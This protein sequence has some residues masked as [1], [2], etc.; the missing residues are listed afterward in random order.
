[1]FYAL[2]LLLVFTPHQ[3][4]CPDRLSSFTPLRTTASST[5]IN[6]RHIHTLSMFKTC[7]PP[8][9]TSSLALCKIKKNIAGVIMGIFKAGIAIAAGACAWA[10][11]AGHGHIGHG[12]DRIGHDAQATWNTL[13]PQAQSAG[14]QSLHAVGNALVSGQKITQESYAQISHSVSQAAQGMMESAKASSL[15]AWAKANAVRPVDHLLAIS[16]IQAAKSTQKELDTALMGKSGIE[17]IDH[18]SRLSALEN[19]PAEELLGKAQAARLAQMGHALLIQSPTL[20][21]LAIP[22]GSLRGNQHARRI[23]SALAASAFSQAFA[24]AL[25]AASSSDQA[26]LWGIPSDRDLQKEGMLIQEEARARHQVRVGNDPIEQALDA[27]M[28]ASSKQLLNKPKQD[29]RAAKSISVDFS[30]PAKTMDVQSMSN[31][32]LVLGGQARLFTASKLGLAAP[33]LAAL[34]D[35]I[36]HRRAAHAAT[37]PSQE[38]T[39]RGSPL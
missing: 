27:A 24:E 15:D 36:I 19:E 13:A 3:Y 14:C 39:P 33:E 30:K 23:Q 38:S 25:A 34:R 9:S 35:K 31:D 37:P 26:A 11:I 21:E 4:C 10:L 2:W 12:F 29:V 17:I 20:H 6:A 28:R 22:S 32:A 8:G 7:G 18:P 16:A 1:M 5:Y